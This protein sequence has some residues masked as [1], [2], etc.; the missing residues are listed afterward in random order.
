MVRGRGKAVSHYLWLSHDAARLQWRARDPFALDSAPSGFLV[1]RELTGCEIKH[2]NGEPALLLHTPDR[3][4]AL[5][6]AEG[7]DVSP[8]CWA[9]TLAFLRVGA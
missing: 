8:T 1:V 3:R 9:A 2:K 7:G 6:F 5:E 4:L